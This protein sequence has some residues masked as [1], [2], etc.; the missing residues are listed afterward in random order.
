MEH[1]Q[2][3]KWTLTGVVTKSKTTLVAALAVMVFLVLAGTGCEQPQMVRLR[4]RTF[5]PKRGIVPEYRKTLVGALERGE[6]RHV[7]VQL[8][9]HL[10]MMER[11]DLEEQ[12]IKLLNYI[13]SMTWQAT[14]SDRRALEFTS[15]AAVKRSPILGTML[16][17]GGVQPIDCVAPEILETRTAKWIRT[18]DN[19]ERYSVYFYKDVSMDK[20][21]RLIQALGGK[22]DDEETLTRGFFVSLPAGARDKLMTSDEV[23][24]IDLYPPPDISDNDG[25]TVTV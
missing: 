24:L 12:G 16:W 5:T 18:Q 10:D 9:K 4:S 19:R 22:I 11:A 6:K 14:V 13:G 20:G 25:S 3:S 8:K 2:V 7:Y 21:R 23:K 1:E 15:S 17:I